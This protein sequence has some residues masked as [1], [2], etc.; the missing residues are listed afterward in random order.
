LIIII[1]IIIKYIYINNFL[2]FFLKDYMAVY[3]ENLKLKGELNQ[4]VNTD[5]G[6]VLYI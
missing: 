5:G 1:I 4:N 2:I 3:K 6:L